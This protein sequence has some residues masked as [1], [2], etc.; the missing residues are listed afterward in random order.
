MDVVKA[1]QTRREITSFQDKPVPNDI[2]ES[3]LDAGYLAPTGNN[4]PS[5]ELILVTNKQNLETLEKTTPYMEWLKEASAAIVITGR[6]DVSKYWIQD[7][8]ISSSFIWLRAT[9][10]EVGVGFGAVYNFEDAKESA[11][12]EEWVRNALHIPND[13]RVLAILGIGYPE[14]KPNAK[15]LP[16]KEEIIYYESF[17]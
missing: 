7:G 1:I 8:S 4:L 11:K 10:L 6:P 13:R 15:K 14:N 17:K 16:S 2:L 5:R 12:R 9:E 3:I